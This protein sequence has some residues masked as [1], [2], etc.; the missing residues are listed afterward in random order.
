MLRLFRIATAATLI[1]AVLLVSVPVQLA[2]A[3][4]IIVTRA[5]D[6]TPD[7]CVSSVDCSLR[8]AIIAAEANAGPDTINFNIPTCGSGC[9]ISPGSPL[10]TLANGGTTINGYS[11]SPATP[12]SGST[13]AIILIQISGGSTGSGFTITS[14]GN[15]IKGLAINQ[16]GKGIDI[17]GGSG[18]TIEGCH[19][20]TNRTGLVDSGNIQH[21]VHL[22]NGA[23]GNTIGGTTAASR[24]VISGND[25]AGVRISG[26]GS[27]S[28]VVSGNYIGTKSNGTELLGN[29]GSGVEIT[30][31]PRYNTIGGDTSGERNLISGNTVNGVLISDSSTISNTVSGNRIGTDLAGTASLPNGHGISIEAGAHDN[32]IGG[33][34]AGEANLISGNTNHG[35]RITGTGSNNNTLWGNMIGLASDGDTDLGNGSNGVLIGSGAASNNIGGSAVGAG[36]VISGNDSYGVKIQSSGTDNNN[37]VGNLIGLN[38]TGTASRGNSMSGVYI[39]LE[40]ESNTI[41]GYT[42]SWKNVISGNGGSG[43]EIEGLGTD[44]STIVGNTIGLGSD[45]STDLGNS[46]AGVYLNNGPQNTTIGSTLFAARNVISG[47]DVNGVFLSGADTAYNV[48][49]GNFIG[50]DEAG[51]LVVGNI[52]TGVALGSAAHDNTI[53]GDAVGERNVISGNTFNGVVLIGSG[54]TANTIQGNYIGTDTTGTIDLGNTL[55]GVDIA[56]GAAANT[57]GGLTAGSGNIISGNNSYGVSISGSGT[58]SNSIQGNYIGTNISGAAPLGNSSGGVNIYFGA[59]T[60]TIGGSA[61]NA[62]NVISGNLGSGVAIQSQSATTTGNIIQ[63]NLIGLDATGTTDVGNTYDGVIISFGAQGNFIGGDTSVERNVI[64]GNS[65]HGI[66]IQGV[67]TT[68][69]IVSG[70]YIGTDITGMLDL[71]NDGRGVN[72]SGAAQDNIIGG[73][74]VGERNLIS[75]NDTFG[76]Y[77]ADTNTTGNIVKGNYMGSD[78]TGSAALSNGN[79]GVYILNGAQDNTLGPKNTIA[80]NGSHGVRVD[81]GS[82]DGNVITENSIHDNTGAGIGLSSG[83]N[84]GILAPTITSVVLGPPITIS[85][86]ACND[87]TVEVFSNPDT[88]GEGW[89]YLGS[90]VANSSGDFS[91]NVGSISEIYLTATATHATDGTSEFSTTFTSAIRSIFLP[92]IMR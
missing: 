49:I 12:A 20:G 51:G 2:R 53:G 76:V 69:N 14:S 38:T 92:L 57:I 21:G 3:D 80:F 74:T 47:N 19:I 10:P 28:N 18:N 64:S 72:L 55:N 33:L 54:T 88:D 45:G 67:G 50:T 59:Q 11:Q 63:G 26:F 70:N 86:T 35:L 73:D 40:A 5:D 71:G 79:Y 9:T 6:P 83:A 31:S 39:T 91:L 30:T 90:T 1:A 13:A 75:G 60:N 15:V 37:V 66:S 56:N 24:N 23:S 61:P 44:G 77:I 22:H 82:T 27:D 58:D 42:V 78:A 7:G 48:V 85:G 65:Q 68:G 32:F 81:G 25:Q 29:S 87:C 62:G 16:F 41:G 43:I 46:S 89:H 36:N 8:E 17:D 4:I 84:G 34:L 52:G